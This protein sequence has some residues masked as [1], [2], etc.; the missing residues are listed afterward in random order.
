MKN[1]RRTGKVSREIDKKQGIGSENG[2][3]MNDRQRNIIIGD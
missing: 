3:T 2:I 1:E